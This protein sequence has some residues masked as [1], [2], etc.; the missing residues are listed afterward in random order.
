MVLSMARDPP[1]AS[2]TLW[3]LVWPRDSFAQAL[4]QAFHPS[5]PRDSLSPKP[6]RPSSYGPGIAPSTKHPMVPSMAQGSST[7]TKHPVMLS[8]AFAQAFA[9]PKPLPKPPLPPPPP[10]GFDR[11]S[12][13]Y[14]PSCVRRPPRCAKRVVF[15]PGF[16][17]KLGPCLAASWLHVGLGW[18]LAWGLALAL[19]WPWLGL[20]SWLLL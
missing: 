6:Y 16:G 11:G 17:V 8:V 14:L 13:G 7:S 12:P 5:P 19:A 3:C 9:P 10:T 15:P 20:R 1:Q 2:S 4:A 18:A